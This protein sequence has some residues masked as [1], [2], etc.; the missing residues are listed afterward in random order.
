ML[1]IIFKYKRL[2]AEPQLDT[3]RHVHQ[4]Q[5]HD[6]SAEERMLHGWAMQE[7]RNTA[8]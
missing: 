5:S 3:Q 1:I 7:E 2:D 4:K 6:A 8:G